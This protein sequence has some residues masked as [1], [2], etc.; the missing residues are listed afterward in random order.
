MAA[1]GS[2]PRLHGCLVAAWL[3]GLQG[4]W[5]SLRTSYLNDRE[6][7]SHRFGSNHQS[8]DGNVVRRYLIAGS[9]QSSNYWWA[10][11]VTLGGLGFV[12]GGVSSGLQTDLLPFLSS[13]GIQFFPQ[14]LVMS[15]YGG[16]GLLFGGYLW[17]SLFWD[18][19][20]GFNEFNPR[21]RSVRIFRWGFPGKT[22]RIDLLQSIAEVESIKV[23]IREGIRPRRTIYIR[24]RGSRD[25]PITSIGQPMTL[26]EMETEAA[27]L[28][29]F[30]GV[31][32]E[33]T[34]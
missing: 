20:G 18:V 32:I 26:I 6:M 33:M 34:A 1:P 27:D 10:A 2:P 8:Q 21:S 29:R 12:L 30:I 24:T 14:G 3:V 7:T 5:I 9:R 28:A 16:L 13:R 31:P 25:I 23:E 15:F 22:R 11:I 4:N 19:G 17:L